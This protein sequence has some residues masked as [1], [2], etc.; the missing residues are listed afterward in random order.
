[1]DLKYDLTVRALVFT[2]LR[3]AELAHM[4]EG[5]VTWQE[6]RLRVPAHEPCECSDCRS[7]AAQA[8]GDDLV[9][10]WKPKTPAGA[11]TIPVKDTTTLRVMREYFKRNREYSAT[12]QTVTNR[13]D[14]VAEQTG[15]R[16]NVMPHRL[17][18]SYGT[19][20]AANGADS[21][22]IRQT[23]GHEDISSSG[24]YLKY[25]GAQLD[26]QAEDIFGAGGVNPSENTAWTELG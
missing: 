2:G 19:M 1:M 14:A 5:W 13:V 24:W 3:S 6:E 20:I 15:L 7:K 21:Q 12:R 23:M 25:A 22:Y 18:H 9:E 16:T 8:E 4:R 17:R 11:R 26:A 10:W